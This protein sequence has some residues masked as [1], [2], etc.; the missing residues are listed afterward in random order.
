MAG[1][2]T[3]KRVPECKKNEL[4]YMKIAR[5]L[6]V[7]FTAAM[8]TST[9]LSSTLARYTEVFTGRDTALIARWNMGARGEDD[10]EGEFYN[11]GFTFDL[12]DARSI[13]PMDFGKKSFTFRGGGSDVAI[14]YDVK[15]NAADLMKLTDAGNKAVI[16]KESGKD[17]YAPFIF[18]IEASINDGATDAVP[19]IFSP[20]EASSPYYGTGWFRPKDILVDEDGY[21]SIFSGAPG[22][23]A[24]S[25]D[26]VTIT[27]Y[28]Q[29][30]TSYYIN[31][32]GVD[33]VTG[34]NKVPADPSTDIADEYLPYYQAAYD[35][36][37]G[38][39]GLQDRYEAAANAVER[40]LDVHGSPNSDGSWPAHDTECPLSDEEHDME[41]EA[42]TDPEEQS[43][44]LAAHGGDTSW[45]EHTTSCSAD[46]F[47]QYNARVRAADRA[48]EA[49]ETTFL[50][51]YDDYDTFAANA[52]AARESV[53][54]MF[55]ITGDQIAP[56]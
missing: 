38:A 56:Q 55:R 49:C 16:A 1:I 44:Y 17:V 40:Y 25:N 26:E 3:E 24:G 32:T 18:K 37:Y 53:K 39:G 15:M 4:V 33:A 30:N 45:P 9:V 10:I 52:L 7:L 14:A 20:Y 13:E 22:F 2:F 8:I 11:K 28:W 23:S 46:H 27:V 50:A 41:Y 12:F 51:A 36:Y 5:I 34:P 6:V 43:A 54:V 21:F 35:E 48:L 47:A 42:I 19:E 31:D 29:W